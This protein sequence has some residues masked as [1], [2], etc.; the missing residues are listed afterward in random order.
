[1]I[2]KAA[3]KEELTERAARA[4][5]YARCKQ[6]RAYEDWTPQQCWDEASS[7]EKTRT[8]EQVR[9]ALAVALPTA[10]E[11]TR[12]IEAALRVY[13]TAGVCWGPDR[14]DCMIKTANQCRCAQS[15][16]EMIAT[17]LAAVGGAMMIRQ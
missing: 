3:M 13:E 4:A 15:V 17:Y 16:Q 8:T 2:G 5:W 10:E 9:A 6:V 1:M 11:H 14:H 12:G 7:I